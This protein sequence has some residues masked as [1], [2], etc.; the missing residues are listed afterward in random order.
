MLTEKPWSRLHLDHAINFMGTDWLLL[1]DAYSKYPCIHPT[2]S[3]SAQATINLLEQDFAYFGYPHILVMGTASAFL[4]EEF[5]MWWK[6]RGIVHLTRAPYHPATNGAAERLVQTFK[7]ALKKSSHPPRKALQEFL[8]QFP[9][10]IQPRGS[11]QK[12]LARTN[13]KRP[14]L[15]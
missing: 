7:Q 1:T 13:R 15:N 11:K 14:S 6:D 9:Q 8:M 5:Q 4:S 3:V 12:K 2:Q 10:H